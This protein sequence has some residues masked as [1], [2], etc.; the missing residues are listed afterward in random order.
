LDRL[1]I[2]KGSRIVDVGFGSNK[3]LLTLS[4]IVGETGLVFGIEHSETLVKKA[5]REINV[6][7]VR[8][9]VG[10]AVRLPLPEDSAK[11]ILFKGAL[12]EVKDVQQALLEAKRVCNNGGKIVIV[13]FS[14]FPVTW[15]KMSNLKWRLGHPWRILGSPPDLHAGFERKQI[16]SHLEKTG[17]REELYEHNLGQGRFYGH[18]VTMFLATSTVQK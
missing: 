13:D 6:A 4:S 1:H 9:S 12:H 15:L 16:Q 17:L 3:E 5:E 14:Q 10:D 8:L 7:N 11:I 18:P 2:A